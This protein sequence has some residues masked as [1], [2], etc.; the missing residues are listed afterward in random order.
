MTE[1]DLDRIESALGLRLPASYRRFMGAYPRRLLEQQPKWADVTKWE[2]ADDPD[3]VIEFNE[4][5]RRAKPGV[6]F[7]GRPWPPHYF[8]FGSEARQNWYFLD[9]DAGT[10]AVYWYH[11]EMGDVGKVCETLDQ[12]PDALLEAWADVESAESGGAP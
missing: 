3:R 1:A 4:H 8:V 2:L 7:D 11:H 9:L 12:F 5:V 10:P 6:Y